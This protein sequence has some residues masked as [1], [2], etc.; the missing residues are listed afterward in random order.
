M[1]MNT[2]KTESQTLDLTLAL[3]SL[4][5]SLDV[6]DNLQTQL[7][8]QSNGVDKLLESLHHEFPLGIQLG[9]VKGAPEKR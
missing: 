9:T 7:I 1:I 8:N 2:Q 6:I 3:T 5:S 4:T